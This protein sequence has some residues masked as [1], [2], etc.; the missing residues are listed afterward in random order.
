MTTPSQKNL[1]DEQWLE[2]PA[3]SELQTQ[4]GHSGFT[5]RHN[6]Q[7]HSLFTLERLEQLA[8]A[9]PVERIEYNLGDLPLEQNPDATPKSGL[10]VAETI[11]QI[12]SCGSW[13]VLKHVHLD[14]DYQ[15]LLDDCLN[16]IEQQVDASQKR[17]FNRAAFIFISSPDA[18]TPFHIDPEN[19]F[20]LQI[21]GSKQLN[22]F[23]ADDRS[24][25]PHEALERFYSR[26]HRN[27]VFPERTQNG[28][29]KGK[30]KYNLGPGDAVHVPQH[31]PHYVR[32]GTEVSISFSIT[33]Q[34]PST[35]RQQGQYWIN[36]QLRKLGL[37]PSP[38]QP[39]G[40]RTES[41]YRTYQALRSIKR[42]LKSNSNEP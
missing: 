39:S 36:N 41:K 42:S 33:F 40:W 37:R 31:A 21:N 6:L 25:V 12:G 13:M 24:V 4:F 1:E 18:I 10:S 16:Q 38:P 7:N 19:N 8:L 34:N 5:L 30:A 28:T 35:D 2:L 23:S 9:L 15:K 32:N 22:M 14:P 3:T 29:A 20:L 27:L 17:F 26:G 11:R